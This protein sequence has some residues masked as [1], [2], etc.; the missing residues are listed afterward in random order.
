MIS[1]QYVWDNVYSYDKNFRLHMARH[2]ARS[3][4]II[5]QQ[6]WAMKLR[7]KLRHQ[8][9]HQ[10][11]QRQNKGRINEACCRFN[12]GRCSFGSSCKYEHKCTYCN[13]FGHAQLHCRKAQADRS[14]KISDNSLTNSNNSNNNHGV[15]V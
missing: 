9:D 5:L 3:W 2:P 8:N 12:Q 14:D 6:A 7:E 11:Y 1:T 15:G 10:N 13:K 4:S